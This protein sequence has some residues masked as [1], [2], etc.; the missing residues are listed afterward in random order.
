MRGLSSGWRVPAVAVG[1]AVAMIAA[2]GGAFAA[3]SGGGGTITACAKKHTGTLYMA[4]K[5]KK[6]DTKLS[7]N[8]QGPAGSPGKDGANGTDGATGADGHQGNTGPAGPDTGPA[9]GSLAGNYPNPSIGSDTVA[10]QAN[11]NPGIGGSLCRLS[12]QVEAGSIGAAEIHTGAVGS[13]QLAASA[14]PG[15]STT[16]SDVTF[17]S[18]SSSTPIATLSLPAGSY[19]VNAKTEASAWSSTSPSN[20]SGVPTVYAYCELVTGAVSDSALFNSPLG[21]PPS[22]EG[23]SNAVGSLV[24]QE[25]VTLASAGSASLRCLASGSDAAGLSVTALNATI[26][27]VRITSAN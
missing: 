27:A 22:V 7:W 1:V 26:D 19:L 14:V 10:G 5:C 21:E 20:P 3:S 17:N 12:A 18:N 16:A 9:G 24:M 15:Y 6:G 23:A 2:G 11:C 8:E 13:T 4:K 25:E